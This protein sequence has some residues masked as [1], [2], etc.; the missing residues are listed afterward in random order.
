MKML[1]NYLS[2]IVPFLVCSI[3][4]AND[5]ESIVVDKNEIAH[6]LHL[7]PSDSWHIVEKSDAAMIV[8]I[9]QDDNIL[10]RVLAFVFADVIPIAAQEIC[11][12]TYGDADV[13]KAVYE[14]TDMLVT[15]R[16]GRRAV[17]RMRKTTKGFEVAANLSAK[18]VRGQNYAS[19]VVTPKGK[20]NNLTN[21]KRIK[22]LFELYKE[23]GIMHYQDVNIQEGNSLKPTTYEPMS[24][25]VELDCPRQKG[26]R[27]YGS[28]IKMG[29]VP[30]RGLQFAGRN[31]Q[32]ESTYH[33]LQG[34]QYFFGPGFSIGKKLFLGLEIGYLPDVTTNST[35]TFGQ[36]EQAFLGG[37]ISIG[38]KNRLLNPSLNFHYLTSINTAYREPDLHTY[39]KGNSDIKA[40]TF[41]LEIPLGKVLRIGGEIGGYM[42]GTDLG[43]YGYDQ[44]AFKYG[45]AK[46][47]L[48]SIQPQF[49]INLSFNTKY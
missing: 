44:H 12:L 24:G 36:T 19:A 37:K 49:G 48:R 3:T 35:Q 5:P 45:F 2:F 14:A 40:V 4:F 46:I 31:A 15:L 6:I 41:G 38:S 25:T 10:F 17:T 7:R 30:A 18:Q 13:C 43:L 1:R 42:Y 16:G 26:F 23:E 28:L 34:N 33:V 39:T 8:A 47:D 29:C 20:K 22:K 32:S 11:M 9:E 21:A 27:Q